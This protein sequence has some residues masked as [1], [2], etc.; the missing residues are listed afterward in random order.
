MATDL[1]QA[2]PAESYEELYESAD[3]WQPETPFEQ[4]FDFAPEA[5]VALESGPWA[6]TVS[7]TPF[8]GEFGEGEAASFEADS[9]H[10][11]LFELYDTEMDRA[12]GEIVQEASMAVAE[13]AQSLGELS[14]E[15]SER[16]L[17]NWIEPLREQSETMLANLAEQLTNV[18]AASLTED[19]VDR[20]FEQHEPQETGLEQHFEEFL[21]TVWRKAKNAVS[22]VVNLAKKGV[23]AAIKL[24]PGLSGLLDRLKRLVNPLL[25]RVLRMA[26]DRL[27]P[28]L[29]PAARLLAKRFVP[30]FKGELESEHEDEGQAAVPDVAALQRELD[31]AVATL[32]LVGD[33]IERE[34]V[35][36]EHAYESEHEQGAPLEAYYEARATFVDQLE[37]GQDPRQA[38]EQFIPAVMA[39]L[40]VARVVIGIVGRP[41][42]VSFIAGYLAKLVERYVGREASQALSKAIVDV[43]LRMLSLEAPSDQEVRQLGPAAL[44][45]TVEDT[46]RRV[47]ELDEATF[48]NPQ[49][50][51]AALNEAFQQAAAENFPSSELVPE[52]QET[53][54]ISAAW[55]QMPRR[56]R[57]K[58]YKK[59][60]HVF[61]IEITPQMAEAV[62][63]FGGQT[64]AQFLSDK[65]GTKA[66]VRAR[67]AIYQTLPGGWPARIAGFERISPGAPVRARLAQLHP[68]TPQVAGVLLQEPRLGRAIG[69]RFL[70]TRNRPAIGQRLY[71]LSVPGAA[72]P[73]GRRSSEVNVTLD[74]RADRYTVNLYLGEN[75]AQRVAAR[76][77][78]RDIAGAVGIARRVSADGVRIALGGELRRHVRIR[79]E[80]LDHEEFLGGALRRLSP[81]TSGALTGRLVAWA[82]QATAEYFQTRASEFVAATEDRAEGVTLVL[83]MTSPPG[84]SLLRQLLR[85]SATPTGARPGAQFRGTPAFTVRAVAGFR[86][87]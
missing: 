29:R 62:K 35:I 83:T 54:N 20:I 38:L 23:A 1:A 12:L 19:Q 53:S 41:K 75:D 18:D 58:Y 45:G 2:S 78:R 70:S 10:E 59:F 51:E 43:G 33:E 39:I 4:R 25:L 56:G 48:E 7:E 55:L 9:F 28:Q 47:A 81:L 61:D 17:E 77:R 44:V 76:L 49:L 84:A 27:P 5:P 42:V 80:A 32:A 66:P 72:T 13:Q 37:Q 82:A 85:R 71:S 21:K 64:L 57:R 69:G 86:F 34:T 46:L 26:M 50:L 22:G 30:G 87:D 73:S 63:T 11:L 40:P 6:G 79:H 16:F 52:V 24:V 36:A 65:L 31:Y 3:E 15:A 67:L 14:S 60:S 8:V 74:L 68:L